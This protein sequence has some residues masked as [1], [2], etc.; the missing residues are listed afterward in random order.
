MIINVSLNIEKKGI[1]QPCILL[2]LLNIHPGTCIK[3]KSENVFPLHP[4]EKKNQ[5]KIVFLF[6]CSLE[7]HRILRTEVPSERKNI[8]NINLIR[9]FL[10]PQT[11]NREF[12][13]GATELI[14]HTHALHVVSWRQA[15]IV[16]FLEHTWV[17]FLSG[18]K[19]KGGKNNIVFFF[20]WRWKVFLLR[21][22]WSSPPPPKT[23]QKLRDSQRT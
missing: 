3:E 23:P 16:N 5:I 15:S 18:L 10:L 19:G 8:N 13:F 12:F 11:W 21:G 20:V 17:D 2:R 22:S 7:N 14:F 6:F 1:L 4:L 9:F